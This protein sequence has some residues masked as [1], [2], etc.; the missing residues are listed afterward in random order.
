MSCSYQALTVCFNGFWFP[1][2]FYI[3]W[4]LYYKK[5]LSLSPIY[6]YFFLLCVCAQLCLTLCGPMDCSLP[7]SSACQ[8]LLSLELSRQEY[9]SGLPFPTLGDLPNPEMEP[10]SLASPALSGGFFTSSATWEAHFVYENS[11]T[12]GLS[13][14]AMGHNLSLSLLWW[15]VVS[16]LTRG[17]G[18]RVAKIVFGECNG[19]PL[20]YSCLENPMDGAW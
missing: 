15:S 11:Q 3:P 6:Y 1:C 12:H 18:L 10:T 14:S 7:G 8:A 20:Q 13:F 19:T 9:W 16:T 4:W 2:S 5:G 17:R